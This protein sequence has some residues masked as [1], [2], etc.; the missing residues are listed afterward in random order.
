M[1]SGVRSRVFSLSRTIRGRLKPD[2][3]KFGRS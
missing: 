1:E 2:K 3:I